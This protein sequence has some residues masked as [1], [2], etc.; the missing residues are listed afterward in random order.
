[1]LIKQT[2]NYNYIILNWLIIGIL[3]DFNSILGMA[4]IYNS[5]I[6][7]AHVLFNVFFVHVTKWNIVI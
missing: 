4:N 7:R 2:F 3:I 5:V 6:I 1:M